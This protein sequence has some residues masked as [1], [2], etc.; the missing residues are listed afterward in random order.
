MTNPSTIARGNVA[1]QYVIAVT[2]SPAAVA[3]AITAEQ[4]FTVTGVKLGDYVSVNKPTTQAGLG[5]S[6]SRVS[7]NDVLAISFINATAATITPTA[8]EVYTVN[9]NRPENLSTANVSAL[10]AVPA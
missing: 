2:L 8:S 7:A 10:N 4:T 3:N 5:I 9:V 6:G 1:G